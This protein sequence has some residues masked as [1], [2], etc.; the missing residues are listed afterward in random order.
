L[1]RGHLARRHRELAVTNSTLAGDVPI[2]RQVVGRIGKHDIRPQTLHQCLVGRRV[3]GIAAA[4]E[5]SSG[6]PQITRSGNRRLTDAIRKFI[7]RVRSARVRDRRLLDAQID[8][9]HREAGDFEAEIEFDRREL[10]QDLAE[11]PLIPTRQ[12]GQAIVGDAEGPRPFGRKVLDAD[13][14]DLNPPQPPQR[15]DPA[16]SGQDLVVAV[17]QDRDKA[18]EGFDAIGDLTYL[19]SAMLLWIPRVGFEPADRQP[20]DPKVS[21]CVLL[22]VASPD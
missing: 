3:E 11:Q 4:N 21:S 14:R 9:R 7:G 22:H 15:E 10:V 17:D 16:M 18:A 19:P 8:F 5:V 1:K 6:P 2:N 20:L 12:L 13:Y